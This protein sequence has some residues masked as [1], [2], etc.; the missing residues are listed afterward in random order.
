MKKASRLLLALAIPSFF[1]A[2]CGAEEMAK[3]AAAQAA[4]AA[5]H[6]AHWSYQGDTSPAHW[7]DLAS[8]NP[9]CKTGKHQSP[10]DLLSADMTH[11]GEKLKAAYHAAP[12]T[13]VNNGHSV[14]ANLDVKQ[15]KL[16]FQGDE[17]VLQQI[18]FHSPSEH[19]LDGVRFPMEMHMVHADKNGKLAV[20]GVFIKEGKENAALKHMFENLPATTKAAKLQEQLD[21]AALVPKKPRAYTYTGSLTTPPCSENVQWIMLEKPITLSP[22]QVAAFE[23]VYSGNNRPVQPVNGRIIN[24]E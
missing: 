7:G 5:G 3:P 14:Q 8:G 18:H 6:A 12:V 17:Y 1:V 22:A 24:R 15:S 10:I 2:G 16:Y 21:I 19:T 23:K 9:E 11:H 13:V 20:L 4:P